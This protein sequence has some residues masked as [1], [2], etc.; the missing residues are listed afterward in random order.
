MACLISDDIQEDARLVLTAREYQTPQEFE[1]IP[2]PYCQYR[3]H[4]GIN[5]DLIPSFDN[6]DTALACSC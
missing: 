4:N 2:L 6:K 5:T 3:L 1:P